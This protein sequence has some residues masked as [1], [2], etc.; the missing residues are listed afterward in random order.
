MWNRLALATNYLTSGNKRKI[1]LIERVKCCSKSMHY[2][3]CSAILG[4]IEGEIKFSYVIYWI[5]LLYSEINLASAM[6]P[7]SPQ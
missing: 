5:V 7:E 1:D 3:K 2:V 6:S 4:K